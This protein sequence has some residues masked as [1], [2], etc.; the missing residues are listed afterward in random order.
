MQ[1]KMIVQKYE[2]EGYLDPIHQGG[3]FKHY[4]IFVPQYNM[5][6]RLD[7]HKIVFVNESNKPHNIFHT[8]I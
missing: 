1:N 7:N 5:I 8:Y 6:I 4:E 3:H 2:V